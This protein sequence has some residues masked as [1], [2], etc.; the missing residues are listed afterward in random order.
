MGGIH[1]VSKIVPYFATGFFPAVYKNIYKK[2][3]QLTWWDLHSLFSPCM[4]VFTSPLKYHHHAGGPVQWQELRT[5]TDS[6]AKTRCRQS[7]MWKLCFARIVSRCSGSTELCRFLLMFLP[8]TGCCDLYYFNRTKGKSFPGLQ[9]VCNVLNGGK[10]PLCLCWS[11][12]VCSVLCWFRL[13][14]Y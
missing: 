6:F 4:Y 3:L 1:A 5:T 9:V 14:K 13:I 10:F 2:V 11:A 7:A 12:V 8:G